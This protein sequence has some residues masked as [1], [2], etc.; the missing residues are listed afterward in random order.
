VTD[1][2][3]G[4]SAGVGR[5]TDTVSVKGKSSSEH[6]SQPPPG[7]LLIK[8]GKRI[9]ADSRLLMSDFSMA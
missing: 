6:A 8:E 7:A 9:H 5:R 4:E 2:R 1:W 3:V